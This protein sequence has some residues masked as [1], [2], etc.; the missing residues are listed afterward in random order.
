MRKYTKSL[1]ALFLAISLLISSYMPIFAVGK[2]VVEIPSSTSA[3]TQPTYS[4]TYN[5]GERGEICTALSPGAAS[6][7]TG[8]YSISTLMNQSGSTL[9]NTL[10]TFMRTTHKTTTSYAN[11]SF[12]MRNSP[13]GALLIFFKPK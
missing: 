7:Y 13:I 4:K 10:R 2:Y 9:E 11:H 3:A 5:S 1:V 12:I 8:S 6:Y